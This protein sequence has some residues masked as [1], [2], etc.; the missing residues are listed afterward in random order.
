VRRRVGERRQAC[1]HWLNG[2]GGRLAIARHMVPTDIGANREHRA[3]QHHSAGRDAALGHRHRKGQLGLA[4][5]IGRLV[6]EAAGNLVGIETQGLRIGPHEADGIGIAGQITDA[7]ILD[8]LKERQAN[9]QMCGNC[10]QRPAQALAG[11]AQI[12]TNA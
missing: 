6:T 1:R 12:R 5:D 7:T 11:L 8:R 3:Q 9:A 2:I 10:R 4:V